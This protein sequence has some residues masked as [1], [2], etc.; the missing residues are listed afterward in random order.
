MKK[1]I[2]L[3]E[4]GAF[5]GVYTAGA[6]DTLMKHELYLD[7]AGV[8]AGALIGCNY[9]ARQPGRSRL[10]TIGHRHDTDYVG[11][12]AL[13]RT[14]NLISF[15]YLFND[16]AK[17]HPFDEETFFSSPQKFFCV[18]TDIDTGL[19]VIF[20][21]DELG[22]DI[23]PAM[24]ASSSLPLVNEP[25]Q[26]GS[27]LCLDGGVSTAIPLWWAINSGYEKIAV[28][29]TR[30]RDY[31]KPP[32]TPAQSAMCAVRYAD[33]PMLRENLSTVS[34]RYNAL[35]R[36]LL[37]LEQEGRIFVLA[38]EKPVQVERMEDDLAKLQQ[39]Y[40]EGCEEMETH[41]ADLTAYLNA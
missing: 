34:R 15:D 35:C 18:A 5:R 25:V 28:I 19:P 29:R 4:G 32:E 11:T 26:V 3:L 33:R 12:G 23:Y 24:A 27:H 40:L 2:L 14:K 16:L 20:D 31:L 22:K 6:L 30:N 10:V 13:R 36:D 7:T 37:R 17:L 38:P 8:S 39:F 41:L 9:V 21:R 1:T